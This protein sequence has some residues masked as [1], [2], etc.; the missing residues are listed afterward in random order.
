MAKSNSSVGRGSSMISI[1]LVLGQLMAS[2]ETTDAQ[3]GVCN[4]MI[5]D[6]LPTQAEVI[7]LY[8]TYKIQRMRLYD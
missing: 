8:K 4:G 5:G 7:A 1:I 6:D 3:I 2:F